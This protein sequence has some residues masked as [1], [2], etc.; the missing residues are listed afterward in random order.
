[1]GIKFFR[2]YLLNRKQIVTVNGVEGGVF[3]INIG[4]GQG[5]VLGPTL[6]KICIM[7]MHLCTSLFCVKFADDS[8]FEGAF[9]TKDET[10]SLLNLELVKIA[11]W[12]KD[13]R[14]T[15]HPD[16]SRL[17]IHSKDK[18]MNIKLNNLVIQRC[19]YGLQEESVR[20]LG[21]H[22]DENLDWSEHIRSVNKKN[23]KG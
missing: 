22:I 3:A 9:K 17:I 6:F 5:T 15:L 21:I 13:N 4:V 1:M 12:F 7:D 20:L 2:S 19:G 11:K 16:K 8:T 18:I 10:E 23:C 14:L